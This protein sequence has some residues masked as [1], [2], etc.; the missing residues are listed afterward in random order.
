MNKKVI[1]GIWSILA[2]F[3]ILYFFV[4]GPDYLTEDE[5]F[6]LNYEC[7]SEGGTPTPIY[8]VDEPGKVLAVNCLY[9]WDK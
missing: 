1:I 2:G 6:T 9:E 7:I 8:K 5:V 3:I 4:S